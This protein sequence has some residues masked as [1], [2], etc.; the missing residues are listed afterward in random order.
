MFM[1]CAMPMLERMAEVRKY[2]TQK[3]GM[4]RRSSFLK[5]DDE[6]YQ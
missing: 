5:D 2:S 6:K 3:A 1:V 4:M